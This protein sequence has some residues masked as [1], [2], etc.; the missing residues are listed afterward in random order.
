MRYSLTVSGKVSDLEKLP[1]LIGE[2][3][4]FPLLVRGLSKSKVH[5]ILLLLKKSKPNIISS[6]LNVIEL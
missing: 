6:F 4:L 5:Q 2:L 3:D 1:E